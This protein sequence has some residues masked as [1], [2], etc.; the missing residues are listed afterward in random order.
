MGTILKANCHCGYENDKI[1]FGAGMED[2][3]MC[4]VPAL[5]N[6]SSEIEMKNI[7]RFPMS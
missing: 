6:G 7:N 3:G 5:K 1:Y 4:Y 2:E